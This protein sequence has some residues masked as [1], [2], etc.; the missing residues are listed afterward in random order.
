MEEMIINTFEGVEEEYAQSG[1]EYVEMFSQPKEPHWCISIFKG[2]TRIE[3]FKT[4]VEKEAWAKV[5]AF[6]NGEIPGA[7][8]A[9]LHLEDGNIGCFGFSFVR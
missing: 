6:F 9:S 5:R 8:N 2:N 3:Y 1:A 4:D 7:D